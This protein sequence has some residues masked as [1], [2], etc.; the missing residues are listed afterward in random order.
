MLL[1]VTNGSDLT[2]QGLSLTNSQKDLTVRAFVDGWSNT[3]FAELN[4]AGEQ[5]VSLHDWNQRSE[6]QGLVGEA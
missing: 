2:V 6:D 3:Q 1:E 5:N 4:R